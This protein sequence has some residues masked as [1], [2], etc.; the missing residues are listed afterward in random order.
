M[1][2]KKK[3]QEK[4]RQLSEEYDIVYSPD[5][6]TFSIVV[7]KDKNKEKMFDPNLVQAGKLNLNRRKKL[8]T[9]Y[10]QMIEQEQRKKEI[11]ER[12]AKE[13]K[14]EAD[15]IEAET[16]D[17]K[18]E[19]ESGGP[20]G[21]GIVIENNPGNNKSGVGTK[22]PGSEPKKDEEITEESSGDW[23]DAATIGG[24]VLL[25]LLGRKRAVK[26]IKKG[27]QKSKRLGKNV[28]S[29]TSNV[30]KFRK[31]QD[32]PWYRPGKAYREYIKDTSERGRNIIKWQQ[33]RVPQGITSSLAYR[34]PYMRLSDRPSTAA[35]NARPTRL[36]PTRYSERY[37]K[38][39]PQFQ[40][41]TGAEDEAV[42]TLVLLKGLKDAANKTMNPFTTG[43]PR[44]A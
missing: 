8:T 36:D 4:A 34:G 17:K 30:N 19:S 18:K 43:G 37:I 44:L 32:L 10:L 12:V 38:N 20:S 42:R 27:V 16:K 15:K 1:A 11:L 31:A 6:S 3:A 39:R 22:T 2:A 24:L 21:G 33:K 26:A 9:R 40:A 41:G 13:A 7:P 35:I 29:R 5:G 28:A 25:G 14:D 23:G